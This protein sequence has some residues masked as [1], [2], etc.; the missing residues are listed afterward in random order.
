[1]QRRHRSLIIARETAQV[2]WKDTSKVGIA[3]VSDG[4]GGFYV[5]ARYQEPGNMI[6]EAAY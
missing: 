3:A 2:V 1:M 6:G 5:V 4:A